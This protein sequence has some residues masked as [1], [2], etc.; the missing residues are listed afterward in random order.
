MGVV[1]LSSL[2]WLENQ[3]TIVEGAGAAGNPVLE[4]GGQGATRGEAGE[5]VC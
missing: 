3:L 4:G 1:C 2:Y 5:Q